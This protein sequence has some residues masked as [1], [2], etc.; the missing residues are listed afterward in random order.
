MEAI[1]IPGAELYYEQHFLPPEEAT[2][3]FNTLLSKCAW[4]RHKTSF[5]HPV[6][7][8]EA[9][10][11]D[12]GTHYTYSRRE[13]KPLP[14]FPE[15]LSLRDRVEEATPVA[16]Y[17][18]LSL[19]RLGYNAV[20]CNLYRDGNDSV[21]LHADAEPEMGPVI[22]SVSLGA[23]RLFRLKGKS[24]TVAFSQ[25]LPQGSLLIMAGNTQKLFKHEV[26]KEPG[27][28]QPRINL[29][30]RRIEHK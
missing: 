20:L 7:R 1:P 25:R 11:G 6:P 22:A 28:T 13:Y 3:L 17:T 15:L 27:V 18:N 9:Y 16:A 14:W 19:P 8:D 30:F 5:G 26:P 23:E 24:G 10:Y 29:T 21:G 12:P 2:Q 4:Q